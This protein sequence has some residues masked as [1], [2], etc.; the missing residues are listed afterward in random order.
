MFL[1]VLGSGISG[2]SK[3]TLSPRLNFENAAVDQ[4]N[5][6]AENMFSRAAIA[7]TARAAGVG[8]DGPADAGGAFGGI[9]SVELVRF[10]AAAAC[11]VSSETPAPAIARPWLNF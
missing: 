3:S 7:E 6:Q 2:T 10:C 1:V 4:D 5:A 8:R 9:G 11:R